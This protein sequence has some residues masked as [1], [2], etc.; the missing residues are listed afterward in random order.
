MGVLV[1][2]NRDVF[3][4]ERSNSLGFLGKLIVGFLVGFIDGFFGVVLFGRIKECKQYNKNEV[5]RGFGMLTSTEIVNN[6]L[7]SLCL[8]VMYFLGV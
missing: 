1:I 4:L 2:F 5:L 8:G 3:R 7:T 6:M